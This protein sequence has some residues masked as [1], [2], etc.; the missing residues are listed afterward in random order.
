VLPEVIIDLPFPT[1]KPK[2]NIISAGGTGSQV[3]GAFCKRA[4]QKRPR[5]SKET[6][7]C[8]EPTTRSHPILGVKYLEL[9]DGAGKHVDGRSELVARLCNS[10]SN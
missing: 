8:K 3:P 1:K 6:Y 2:P 4:L 7:N 5:F 10:V 9:F